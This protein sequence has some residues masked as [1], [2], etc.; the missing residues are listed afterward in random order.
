MA[1]CLM[2]VITLRIESP[3]AAASK[4]S[5]SFRQQQVAECHFAEFHLQDPLSRIHLLS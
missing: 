3:N 4:K 1:F 2:A 5:C